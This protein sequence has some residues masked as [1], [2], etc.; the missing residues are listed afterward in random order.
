MTLALVTDIGTERRR[1]R[2]VRIEADVFI[3]LLQWLDGTRYVLCDG[4]PP[5]ARVVGITVDKLYNTIQLYVESDAFEPVPE[6]FVPP[7]LPITIRTVK[8]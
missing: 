4:L 7:L 5:D 2:E 8:G 6:G 1:V 3:N